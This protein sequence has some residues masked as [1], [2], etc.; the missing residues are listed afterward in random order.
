MNNSENVLRQ[1]VDNIKHLV[2][3]NNE[4]VIRNISIGK[5]TPLDATIVY[6]D[7]L[8]K[9]DMIDNDILKPLM[10]QV[11]EELINITNIEECLCKKYITMSNV[12]I[13]T[14]LN[15]VSENIKRGKTVVLIENS[16]NFIIVD[17]TSG[18]HRAISDPVNETSVRGP[19]DGFIE[20]LETNLSIMKR[21][22]KDKSLVTEKFV[23]GRIS[24]TDAVLMY[25]DG[26]VDMNLLEKVKTKITAIDV[27]N[28]QAT[29]S[30]EQYV[31][32]YPFS[33]FPQTIATERP[34]RLQANLMEGRIALFLDGSPFI[35]TFPTLF[36][37]FFQTV[38]DY[39]QRT[40]ISSFIRLLRYLAVIVVI[41][42]PAVYV[43][44]VKFNAELIPLDLVKTIIETGT[45]VVLTPFLSILAMNLMV[46]FLREGGLRLPSKIGQTLSVV[47]GIIIG[48]SAIQSKFISSTSLLIVGITTIATF[49]IPN[50]EMSLSIRLLS[51]PTLIL[52]NWLG[53]LGVAMSLIFILT[54][55][56]SLDSFGVPYFSF[57]KSDLKDTIFRAPIWMM[58]KN[59]KSIPSNNALRQTDFRWKFWRKRNG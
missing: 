7:G 20:D 40:I 47:G 13:E 28:I 2:G 25:I 4:L 26:V 15:K 58:N 8:A 24:Q 17:T 3:I 5:K 12:F 45:G 56:C 30:I 34:D 32:K 1:N 44:L 50:Y 51:Y 52:A 11:E 33:I 6:I 49:L 48:D 27:D 55:L 35:M 42:L 57:K 18:V 14:D 53:M 16:L 46:E 36:V 9:K 41:I 10:L 31:E 39:Y 21:K 22:I 59:P 23:L 43:T 29:S 37:E 19:R 54:Y 38:E